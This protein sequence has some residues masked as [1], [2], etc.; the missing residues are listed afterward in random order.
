L[1][2]LFTAVSWLLLWTAA[3]LFDMLG[4][5]FLSVL[6]FRD[7]GFFWLPVSLAFGVGVHFADN[8]A[9]LMLA[10]RTLVL[11]LLK[12][13]AAAAALI[14][15]MFSIALLIKT[16]SLLL[17]QRRVIS[18]TWL[19][20]LAALNIY[21]C[22]AGFQDGSEPEP[23]PRRLGVMLRLAMPLLLLVCTLALYAVGVR[24][25]AYG[26]TVPRI[27][28][29][30]VAVTAFAYAIGYVWAA[31]RASPW[32]AGMARVN[33]TVAAALTVMLF[34]MLTPILSP[35]RM[36]AAN[37]DAR[38]R[39]SAGEPDGQALRMLRTSTGRYGTERLQRLADAVDTTVNSTLRA[40]AQS[41]RQ[42]RDGIA[43][44][45]RSTAGVY[46]DSYPVGT[47]VDEALRAAVAAQPML[48]VANF[49]L[50]T[51]AAPCP[52][53]QIDLDADGSNEALVFLNSSWVLYESRNGQ[54][55]T[56]GAPIFVGC[57]PDAAAS[58]RC[59]EAQVRSELAAGNYALVPRKRADL[60][61]GGRR[62][63][64]PDV[65]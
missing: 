36:T 52:V 54:W 12:W 6:L 28:G 35:A 58:G 4:F 65:P 34:L 26:L 61:I 11:S 55:R 17:E 10:A 39:A 46:L 13:L 7:T 14:L 53:L 1:A 56:A 30:L 42:S 60:R 31:R 62:L 23:Y 47:V 48:A 15:A 25:A 9:R 20:W 59:G 63:A 32:M 29:L 3:M 41:T 40:A 45:P 51:E 38:L 27:W 18:A 8:S 57:V 2:A 44:A 43:A 37:L 5:D 64:I 19:L 49:N 16:P 21:L 22:N 50:C 33:M 24:I